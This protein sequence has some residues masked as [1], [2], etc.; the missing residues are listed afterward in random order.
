MPALVPALVVTV[1]ILS[2]IYRDHSRRH[3]ELGRGPW[4][5]PFVAWVALALVS[6]LVAG[7]LYAVA[8]RR[9][10]KR[11]EAAERR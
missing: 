10:D 11:L 3:E 4:G 6:G 1:A 5:W 2:W 9:Q 8:A 7:I